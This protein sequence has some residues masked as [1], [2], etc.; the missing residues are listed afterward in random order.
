MAQVQRFKEVLSDFSPRI[1]SSRSL[2]VL[3]KGEYLFFFRNVY[4]FQFAISFEAK[5]FFTF[6]TEE[7]SF[8]SWS[9]SLRGVFGQENR[10]HSRHGLDLR[11]GFDVDT[12][13]GYENNLEKKTEKTGTC[14]KKSWSNNSHIGFLFSKRRENLILF[15]VAIVGLKREKTVSSAFYLRP[16]TKNLFTD[17]PMSVNIKYTYTLQDPVLKNK[18]TWI[19]SKLNIGTRNNKSLISRIVLV[20]RQCNWNVTCRS[21]EQELAW[22]QRLPPFEYLFNSVVSHFPSGLLSHF[23]WNTFTGQN[24]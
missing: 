4:Y 22:M 16:V 19:P 15:L 10:R 1:W 8:E 23:L 14:W 21:V 5:P 17:Q 11:W 2:A 9:E 13:L 3:N 24:L 18:E 6:R 20:F 7:S 12:L